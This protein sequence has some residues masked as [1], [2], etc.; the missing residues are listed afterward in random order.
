MGIVP[1]S[2]DVTGREA[3][4]APGPLPCETIA[5]HRLVRGEDGRIRG[6]ESEVSL[7][8]YSRF[9]HGD[10]RWAR[11]FGHEVADMLLSRKSA[12]FCSG[13]MR[14]ERVLLASFPYKYV[15]TAAANMVDH[16]LARI[17]HVLTGSGRPAA[18]LL[19][20]FKYPWQASIE[21][22]FPTMSEKERRLMLGNVRLSVDRSRLEGAHLV[23][24]DDVRVTG[25]TQD[26]LLTFL[27]EVPGLASLTVA[28]LCDVA[29]EVARE[30]PAVEFE[31]NHHE[32]TTLEHVEAIAKSG[33]FRWNV[34][35]AKFVLEERDEA[36]FDAFVL[37]LGDRHLEELYRSATLNEYHFEEKYRRKMGVLAAEM[38]RRE[39]V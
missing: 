10:E 11:R 38:A 39:L 2:F 7:D 21:H 37:T 4:A 19:H 27:S 13:T 22:Y 15:P 5:V 18:G 34:R 23:V 3:L 30:N 14:S 32:V 17:N 33:E 26:M 24:I 6:R 8:G 16:T 31:I 36:A 1:G 20:V 12:L 9:K 25:A 29:P 28:F 35:V